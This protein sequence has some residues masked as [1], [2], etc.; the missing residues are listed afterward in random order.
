MVYNQLQYS[1]FIIL[2]LCSEHE[3]GM[4]YYFNYYLLSSFS[5]TYSYNTVLH[6]MIVFLTS[7]D[8]FIISKT[9]RSIGTYMYY[10]Y[11]K[12]K[13]ESQATLMARFFSTI[14]TI[15]ILPHSYTQDCPSA[16]NC[17][18]ICS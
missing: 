10:F 4:M 5:V 6:R 12:S 16:V 13:D 18:I 2:Y 1:H 8:C 14:L 11:F 9:Q 7:S 15:D 3:N 17:Q